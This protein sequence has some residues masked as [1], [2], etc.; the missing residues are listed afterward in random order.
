MTTI[1][2]EIAEERLQRLRELAQRYG[3]PVEELIR[4]GV[5]NMVNRLDDEFNRDV[6]FILEENAELYRRLA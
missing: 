2:I 6:D 5:E 4:V 1:M 3:L